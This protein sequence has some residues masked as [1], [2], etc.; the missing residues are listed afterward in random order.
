[1]ATF[2]PIF[3]F[4]RRARA[5]ILVAVT[6]AATVLPALA[7]TDT[8]TPIPSTATP[9]ALSIPTNVIFQETNSWMGTLAPI[10]AIGIGISIALAVLAYL[11]KM[12]KGSFS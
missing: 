1:M 2:A 11:G 9:V 6:T 5:Y 7:Q 12:I 10:A 4:A 8:P 3:Q